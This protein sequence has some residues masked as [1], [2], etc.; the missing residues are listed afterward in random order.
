MRKTLFPT[1]D[2]EEPRSELRIT[3]HVR[4]C[5]RKGRLLR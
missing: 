3:R 1:L 2:V 4:R 5:Q